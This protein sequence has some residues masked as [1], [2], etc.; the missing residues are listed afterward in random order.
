M[1]K[2]V[3]YGMILLWLSS[4]IFL[5]SQTVVH[6]SV[7][8]ASKWDFKKTHTIQDGVYTFNAYISK[9][10]KT[11][12]IYRIEVSEV[13]TT[14]P[15]NI[16]SKVGNAKVTRL[17]AD[18]S[19]KEEIEFYQNLFGRYV[20]ACH[21]ADGSN[22]YIDKI[23]MITL[24]DSVTEIGDSVF[25]GLDSIQEVRLPKSL[26]TLACDAFYSCDDLQKVTFPGGCKKLW[27]TAFGECTE[28]SYFSFAETSKNF[29]VKDNV[30]YTKDYR[31][32]MWIA[33]GKKEVTIDNRANAIQAYAL[34]N[35]QVETLSI[36]ASVTFIETNTIS[37]PKL[38][39]IKID[40]KNK[41]YASDGQTVYERKT[42]RL[43]IAIIKN[44]STRIS[45]KVSIITQDAAIVGNGE[46]YG[47]ILIHLPASLK[48][49]GSSWYDFCNDGEH[50]IVFYFHAVNPPKGLDGVEGS[51]APIY[52]S[53]YITKQSI[54]VYKKW[55]GEDYNS[56][57]V[58]VFLDGKIVKEKDYTYIL[59]SDQVT[60]T[61]YTGSEE[62][63][64][65]PSKLSGK[66]VTEISAKAFAKSNIEVVEIPD[67]VNTLGEY[68]FFKCEQLTTVKLPKNIELLPGYMFYGC[69][70]LVNVEIP[71]SVVIMGA[72]LFKNCNSLVHIVLPSK[73]KELPGG[74]FYGCTS[75]Q[76]VM[77]PDSVEWIGNYAFA[78][79]HSFTEIVIP[80]TVLECGA[81]AFR[82]CKGLKRVTV[83]S[84]IKNIYYG[85]FYMCTSL[86]EIV[87]SS[88]IEYI[89]Y[90]AF[91]NCKELIS[92]GDITV[93]GEI[94]EKAFANCKN[95]ESVITLGKECYHVGMEAFKNC[96]NLQFVILMAEQYIEK[97]AFL[98]CN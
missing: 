55:F 27:Q 87:M 48:K 58:N 84:N 51:Y 93:T 46:E 1:K 62:N 10:G 4:S 16:P 43:V 2:V 56:S 52:D 40:S 37:C 89:G 11:A 60:I 47:D 88:S 29:I 90:N 75:L 71:D 49:V 82:N 42:K 13:G 3:R 72:Y 86:E 26:Q 21:G 20:E 30:I 61:K 73:L 91:G 95:L 15:L 22:E 57:R 97:D 54:D 70:K 18:M 64:R 12:W 34:M 25:S 69:V 5:I 33:P 24:P 35:N 36:P 31:N 17:V 59:G 66:T 92:V 79:C 32:V 68:V 81:D 39:K 98:G 83:S 7:S 96:E 23:P 63:V 77:I 45:D 65:I 9:D 6:R 41:T 44:N 28:I 80:E 14:E 76:N 38:S 8:A 78:S 94:E 50:S 19:G 85:T 67:T 53:V 74:C